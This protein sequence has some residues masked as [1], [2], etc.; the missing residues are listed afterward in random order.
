MAGDR[1]V[2]AAYT[3]KISTTL[4]ELLEDLEADLH[5]DNPFT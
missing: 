4:R 2:A 3:M 5:D 1:A